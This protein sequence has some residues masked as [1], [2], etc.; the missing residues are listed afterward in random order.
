MLRAM[1]TTINPLE[2]AIEPR[3]A[4]RL[5]GHKNMRQLIQLRWIAIVGQMITIAVVKMGFGVALPL[6]AMVQVLALL[7]AFNIASHLRWHE[8][9]LVSD[10]ELFV[11]LLVDV[12]VL[13]CQLYLSGGTTNPFVFLYLQHVILGAML[14]EARWSW[15]LLFTTAI[16]FAGLAVFS[17]PLP[18][19]L[20][21]NQ[22]L[23]SLYI[24]GMMVCFALNAILLVISI[25]RISR[26]ISERDA[27]LADLR[28]RASEH[29]HILRLGLLASGA[30]HE[31]GS[32]LATMDVILGDWQHM[33]VL[34][35]NA[36]LRQD[37]EDMQMQVERCKRIVS[38]ILLSAGEARGESA[39]KT[40]VRN[41]TDALVAD[42]RATRQPEEF[43]YS[44]EFDP[45]QS[46]AADSILQQMVCNVLDNA[47]EASPRWVGLQVERIGECVVWTITDR[48]PG[49]PPHMLAAVGKPYQSS[50]GWPG[51]GLGLFLA[52]N[53]ARTVGGTLTACNR[54]EGGARV[55]LSLPLAPLTIAPDGT[56]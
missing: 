54:P 13:S 49:F 55:T 51:S 8:R 36:E 26:N 7:I 29:E 16:C 32:P 35:E 43:E 18:L 17:Q 25:N 9:L 24:Q 5:V 4:Q 20:D 53:V 12:G 2:T 3:R 23:G 27:H 37:M 34:A 48:G 46:I 56:V 50:K 44:Q 14:L 11:A 40:T 41:F 10:H 47:L 21:H 38:G 19:P 1:A 39:V 30:A 22:G 6:P 52:I 42:W 45:D 33:R 28:Q 15:L 31:L